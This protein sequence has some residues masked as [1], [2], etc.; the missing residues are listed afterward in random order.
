MILW[1]EESSFQ[2]TPPPANVGLHRRPCTV[3]PVKHGGG[4]VTVWRCMSAAGVGHLTISDGAL[5]SGH[6]CLKA[7]L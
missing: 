3:P 1:S 2:V 4:N 6:S 5:N 7:L